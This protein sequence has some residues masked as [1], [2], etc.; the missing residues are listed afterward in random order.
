M[1]GFKD[2]LFESGYTKDIPMKK[3][4]ESASNLQKHLFH[5]KHAK[6]HR[7]KANSY[8]RFSLADI[9]PA[10]VNNE[11]AKKHERMA[12]KYGNLHKKELPKAKTSGSTHLEKARHHFDAAEASYAKGDKAHEKGNYGSA[13]RHTDAGDNHTNK[14]TDYMAL[15]RKS[16]KENK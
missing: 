6:F 2:F 1:I 13:Q 15:H 8:N 7:D 5:T 11:V 9:G 12:K 3:P 4:K 10:A 16:L 14:A